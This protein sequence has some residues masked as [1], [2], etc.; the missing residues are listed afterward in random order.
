MEIVGLLKNPAATDVEYFAQKRHR[1]WV[2]GS[3]PRP[4]LWAENI[5]T[6]PG[7]LIDTLPEWE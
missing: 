2:F 6:L 1:C 4:L 5:G 3:M 7:C